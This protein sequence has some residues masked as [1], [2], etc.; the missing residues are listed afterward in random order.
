MVGLVSKRTEATHN[1]LRF[2]KEDDTPK[3]GDSGSEEEIDLKSTAAPHRASAGRGVRRGRGVA[4]E[5]EEIDFF[6]ARVH[7][8][9]TPIAGCAVCSTP[10]TG[11]VVTDRGVCGIVGNLARKRLCEGCTKVLCAVPKSSKEKP[12]FG[13]HLLLKA[14][15]NPLS[16]RHGQQRRTGNLALSVEGG[17]GHDRSSDRSSGPT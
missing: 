3:Q 15:S 5:K 14:S 4:M 16:V 13:E 1:S 17:G 9:R 6:K 11:C 2:A 12:L 10:I 8:C 7:G